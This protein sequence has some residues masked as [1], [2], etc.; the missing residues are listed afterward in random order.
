M[1]EEACVAR[2]TQTQL[3]QQNADQAVCESLYQQARDQEYTDVHFRINGLDVAS[4]HKSVLASTSPVFAGMFQGKTLAAITGV[5]S[6]D[7]V[8][9]DSLV[10]FIEFIY[11]GTFV[12]LCV[13]LYSVNAIL[14]FN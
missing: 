1:D 10:A 11:L 12:V 13:F 8:T 4:A 7:G 9:A 3:L 5:V 14:C 2:L 6:I